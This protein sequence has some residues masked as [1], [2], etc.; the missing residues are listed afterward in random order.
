MTKTRTSSL[1]ERRPR[2]ACEFNATNVVAA[3]ATDGFMIESCAVRPL[4]AGAITPNLT[5]SNILNRD[6]VRS[7]VQDVMSM[8]GT[9]GKEAM[10]ILPDAAC[11]VVLMDFDTLPDKQEDA[12]TIIRFRLK[13]SLPFDVERTHFSWQ[14]QEVNDKLMV[15]AAVTMRSVLEEYESVLREAGLAPGFVMPSILAALGQVD[16]TVPTLV[17]KVDPLTT[18][19]AI[20]AQDSLLLIRTLDHPAGWTC[21]GTQL[22]EDVY[23]SLVF[24]QDTYGTKIEKILVSG[25][26]SLEELNTALAEATGLRAQDLVSISRLGTSAMSERDVLG[27]VVGALA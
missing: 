9:R 17:I 3:R 12:D 26:P 7:T 18:S 21:E 22:A 23:P 20:V 15:L 16:A 1:K 24:F 5:G 25:V 6:L 11:R 14:A 13:K 8:I 27:A 2:V 19:I 10:A 4:P